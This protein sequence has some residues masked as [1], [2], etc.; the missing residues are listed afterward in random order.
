MSAVSSTFMGD[1]ARND[2]A[3]QSNQFIHGIYTGFPS[4][5]TP[6]QPCVILFALGESS[7]LIRR[8]GRVDDGTGLENRQAKASGVRIPLPPPKN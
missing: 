1:I 2:L 5:L 6:L 4:P 7:P 3:P 8:D